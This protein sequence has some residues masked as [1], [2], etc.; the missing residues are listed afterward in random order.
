MTTRIRR[1]I[2]V[3][4][5]LAL[6]TLPFAFAQLSE[7]QEEGVA[8]I[9]MSGEYPPFSMPDENGEMIGFDADVATAIAE[10]LGV[11]ADLQQAQFSAIIAGIQTG[12][13]DFS[14]ASHAKTAER[15][16]AVNYSEIPYYYSGG[17]LFVAEDSEFESLEDLRE[18]G[19]A[20]AVD[21]GGTNQAWLKEHDYPNIATYSGIQ[22]ELLAVRSGRAGAIFTSPIVGNIA[23]KEGQPIKPI[24]E[25]LFEE[26]AWVL[27]A[28]GNPELAAA[29]D[30][31]LHDMREDGTLLEISQKWIG[32]D[33]VT[34]PSD[35]SEDSGTDS[36]SSDE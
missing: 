2:Q 27:S 21:L 1:F 16:E 24:G 34:P 30:A 12:S 3:L 6:A 36:S 33:I 11:E 31:A 4:A 8:V 26:K 13:F 25:L 28:D 22:A 19:A 15:D 14:V 7:I 18:A 32:G 29:I 9:V 23:I 5:V 17:K 20:I 35:S 10:R